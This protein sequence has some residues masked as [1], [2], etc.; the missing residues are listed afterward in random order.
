LKRLVLPQDA[1]LGIF[2][3]TG[4]SQ[5]VGSDYQMLK[6]QVASATNHPASIAMVMTGNETQDC[7]DF[8]SS[9]LK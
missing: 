2:V 3:T 7:S 9:L 5:I 4:N 8:V 1:Q 6:Q